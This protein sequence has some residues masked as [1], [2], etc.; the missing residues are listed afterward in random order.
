DPDHALAHAERARFARDLEAADR[1]VTRWPLLTEVRRARVL[2]RI[3]IEAEHETMYD[4]CVALLDADVE[5]VD[6]VGLV[7]SVRATRGDLDGAW[8][9]LEPRL[10]ST[11]VRLIDL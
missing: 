10:D 11:E 5:D 8:A 1:A 3:A 6:A 4:D 2:L 9:I 7:A